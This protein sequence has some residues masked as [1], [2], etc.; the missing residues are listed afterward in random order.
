MAARAMRILR[1]VL[2]RRSRGTSPSL[3]GSLRGR[4]GGALRAFRLWM[5]LSKTQQPGTTQAA[6]EGV[7]AGR[8]ETA[9]L[10]LTGTPQRHA[11][12]HM[13][14]HTVQAPPGQP[15]LACLSVCRLVPSPPLPVGL[16]AGPQPSFTC[17][18]A[19]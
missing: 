10:G 3:K 1:P 5:K 8:I 9:R 7:P 2:S 13:S 15:L 19:G 16:Q 4:H 12:Q 17:R 18:F 14:T 6:V 11:E